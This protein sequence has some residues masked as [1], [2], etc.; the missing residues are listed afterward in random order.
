MSGT[1]LA[2]KNVCGDRGG[3]ILEK[4]NQEP[5]PFEKAQTTMEQA[6]SEGQG[7]IFVDPAQFYLD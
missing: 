5:L 3:E 2:K 1:E 4:L 6:P 7:F